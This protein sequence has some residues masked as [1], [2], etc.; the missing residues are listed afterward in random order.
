VVRNH[1]VEE[2]LQKK[3]LVTGTG[4]VDLHVLLIFTGISTSFKGVM[5]CGLY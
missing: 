4:D 2:A 5:A 1:W 3:L